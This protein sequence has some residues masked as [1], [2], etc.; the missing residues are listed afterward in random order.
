MS[1]SFHALYSDGRKYGAFLEGGQSFVRTT[2][3]GKMPVP[4][5]VGECTFVQF[6]FDYDP[7]EGLRA[8]DWAENSRRLNAHLALFTPPQRP[9]T[10]QTPQTEPAEP[11]TRT[12]LLPREPGESRL[13]QL[14]RSVGINEMR[15]RANR[16]REFQEQ[17]A[18]ASQPTARQ[19]AAAA[20]VRRLNNSY[21]RQMR[22]RG[23]GGGF[24]EGFVG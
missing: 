2:D 24:G 4:W 20:E 22:P 8:C 21:A 1:L 14:Q 5:R 13:S 16:Q 11:D 3:G 15:A 12:T 19:I 23:G 10:E 7:P 18:Q 17:A 9:A 6:G